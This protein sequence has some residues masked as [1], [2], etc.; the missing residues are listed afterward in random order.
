MYIRKRTHTLKSGEVR[1]GYG[2][3]ECRW[4]RGKPKQKTLFNLGRDFAIPEAD[5]NDLTDR[6]AAILRGQPLLPLEREAVRTSAEDIARRLKEK[7]YDIDAPLDDRDLVITD[8]LRHESIRT[9]GGE[10][11]G[12]Q[13][14]EYLGFM[15]LLRTLGFSE[16][17]VRIAAALVVG[18]MMSPG[19]EAHTY[20]WMLERSSV[21]ELLD[22]EA[23]CPNSLYRVGDQLYAHREELMQGLF[24][25][26]RQ[27]FGF[28]ESILFYDL[29]NVYY[30]GKVRGE[31][32]RHGRQKRSDCPLVTLALALDASGFPLRA[33]VFKGNVS[34]PKTL[35]S[36][37]AHLNGRKVTVIM[38][39]GLTTAANLAWL[40]AQKLDWICVERTQKPPVPTSKPDDELTTRAHTVVKAWI[41]KDDEEEETE[42]K[43]DGVTEQAADKAEGAKV[44]EELRV[45]LWSQARKAT[46][47]SLL[48]KHRTRF[49]TALDELHAGLSKP[50][51]MKNYEKVLV[52]L[53]RLKERYKRVAYQYTVKVKKKGKNASSV[54]YTHALAHTER[55]QASGGYVLRTSHTDWSAAE[56]ARTYWRL[57][58]IERTFRTM[59]SE[60]G[61]R[62]LF[63]RNDDRIAGHLL[64]SVLAYHAV[65]LTQLKMRGIH[66][67][68]SAL[69]LVLNH[70]QRITTMLPQSQDRCIRVTRDVDLTP[71]QRFI[72]SVMGINPT[73]FAKKS[74][75]HRPTKV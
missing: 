67:S 13:A 5:W 26:S 38:D 63:H 7:G 1:V 48:D 53:G 25:Q 68:W 61:L 69:R 46:G 71:F 62:P 40:K 65:H 43:E 14:L 8:E 33:E 41:L 6:V 30:H 4:V 73:G 12:L 36:A 70:W 54:R 23:P 44:P 17:R 64:I 31:L 19:S 10:R 20:N 21:L 74:K 42:T 35:K 51:Y 15:D 55:T 45:Y 56:V 75:E 11:V 49:E 39:A 60:L 32:M 59:K 47:D 9:V 16:T 2:L 37:L 34:E 72:A 3:L 22:L 18:R 52:R 27:L 29:T 57:T 28:A 58:D 50:G 66:E 24:D